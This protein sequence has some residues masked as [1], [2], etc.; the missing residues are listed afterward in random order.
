MYLKKKKKKAIHAVFKLVYLSVIFRSLQMTE[1]GDV[2]E[3]DSHVYP[4]KWE[5][6]AEG[7]NRRALKESSPSFLQSL[8]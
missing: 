5:E 6:G 1:N 4:K 8:C 3:R 2:E 7:T